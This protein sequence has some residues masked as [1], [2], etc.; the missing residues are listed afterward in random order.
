M[1]TPQSNDMTA[2]WY[3]RCRWCLAVGTVPGPAKAYF[4]DYDATCE[5]CGERVEIMGR[6]K[7]SVLLHG[8]EC[9]C[10]D[11]CTGA[12]G[13]LCSCSCGGKNHG[14][15]L[16]CDRPHIA[17][18]IPVLRFP[19]TGDVERGKRIRERVEAL[20]TKLCSDPTFREKNQG[21]WVA[22]FGRYLDIRQA[23]SD[24]SRV[25]DLR[26]HTGREK[27]LTKLGRF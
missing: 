5:A 27:L 24:L 25:E 1:S 2:T 13:P 23:L 7:G 14:A 22:D 19:K 21:R 26:S 18:G 10:D 11:R 15:G 8:T 16:S 12:R 9:P 3:V 4:N 17:G 6:V 20:R